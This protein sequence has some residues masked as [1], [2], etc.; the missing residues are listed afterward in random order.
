MSYITNL[1]TD[2]SCRRKLSTW[3][4]G[5]GVNVEHIDGHFRYTNTGNN[6]WSISDWDSWR[7]LMRLGRVVV[8]AYTA[9]S[10][11]SV[12]VE[13]GMT[14]VSGTTPSGAAWTAAKINRDGNRSI[15]CRG[16]GSLT[17]E[18]MAVYEGDDWPTVQQLLPRFPLFTGSSMPLN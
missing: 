16:S 3:S 4:N 1:Y 6:S 12:A 15:Y 13:S 5:S 7:E 2:P 10:G 17:L 14:L 9:T 18:A 11:L 8:V